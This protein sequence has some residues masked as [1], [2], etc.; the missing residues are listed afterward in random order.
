LP[1]QTIFIFHA[2]AFFENETLFDLAHRLRQSSLFDVHHLELGLCR[3]AFERPL[4]HDVGALRD[5]MLG[6]LR[7]TMLR[8]TSSGPHVIAHMES[9]MSH[10]SIGVCVHGQVRV[11]TRQVSSHMSHMSMG[12]ANN[13]RGALWQNPHNAKH[14]KYDA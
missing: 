13:Y 8:G 11:C 1:T 10:M 3:V 14:D 2:L 7:D 9:H 12:V 4:L 5:A 6:A